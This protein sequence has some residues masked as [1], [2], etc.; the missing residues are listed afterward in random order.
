MLM[1]EIMLGSALV[2]VMVPVRP[3]RLIVSESLALPAAHSPAVAPEAVSELAAVIAS[4]RVHKPSLLFSTSEVLLT[5]IVVPAALTVCH[6]VDRNVSRKIEVKYRTEQPRVLGD[7][8]IK[9]SWKS[10]SSGHRQASD[11]SNTRRF[12]FVHVFSRLEFKLLVAL[13]TTAS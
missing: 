9:F 7:A 13:P 6:G 1:S 8:G 3:V 12:A 5:V 4:R 10:K 11:K 2:N